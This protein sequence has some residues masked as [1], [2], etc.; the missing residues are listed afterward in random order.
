MSLPPA[1]GRVTARLRGFLVLGCALLV[2][3]VS[4][5]GWPA[6][7]LAGWLALAGWLEWTGWLEWAGC[8]ELVLQ[9]RVAV[10]APP[11]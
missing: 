10:C 6:G 3:E 9:L 5:S 7:L 11:H 8:F 1:A 2:R 4:S